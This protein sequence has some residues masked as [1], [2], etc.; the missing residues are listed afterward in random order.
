MN[1]FLGFVAG[2]IALMLAFGVALSYL[3]DV[4]GDT[5]IRV[6]VIVM[7]VLIVLTIIGGLFVAFALGLSH[8]W[9]RAA[10][11]GATVEAMRT[12]RAGIN[13]EKATGRGVTVLDNP[14]PLRQTP[15]LPTW[16]TSRMLTTTQ[17]ER[18]S[19]ADDDD[20]ILI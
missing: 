2:I 3:R 9:S 14:Q 7:V 15:A 8:V 16:P 11:P 1:K 20:E 18:P 4:L 19:F 13:A 6:I 17:T 5:G 12:L 10:G